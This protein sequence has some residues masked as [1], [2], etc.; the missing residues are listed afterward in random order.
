MCPILGCGNG[1][2]HDFPLCRYHWLQVP[3]H[4]RAGV[5]RTWRTL[6][7][8][9]GSEAKHAAYQAARDEAIAAV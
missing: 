1:S 9:P 4:L 2:G 6:Q 5:L 8:D 7:E 3:A